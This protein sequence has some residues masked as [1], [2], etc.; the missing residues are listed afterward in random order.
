M[1]VFTTI[2]NSFCIS[3]LQFRFILQF[4]FFI[5]PVDGQILSF[6]KDGEHLRQNFY[7]V[8]CSSFP[9]HH[10]AYLFAYLIYPLALLV[11]EY[12]LQLQ[13]LRPY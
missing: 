11:E 8:T 4:N 2:N 13:F 9:P 10:Y 3:I 7:L 6:F 12:A 5:D 1:H